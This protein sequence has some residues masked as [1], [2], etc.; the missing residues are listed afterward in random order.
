MSE[1]LR[2]RVSGEQLEQTKTLNQQQPASLDTEL[3]L[4]AIGPEFVLTFPIL[5]GTYRIGRSAD[6]RIQIDTSSISRCHASLTFHHNGV[7]LTDLGSTN[8]TRYGARSIAPDESVA[9]E[10]GVPFHLG[11]VMLILQ[12]RPE[13]QRPRRIWSFGYFEG[14]LEDECVRADQSGG[15]FGLAHIHLTSA[16][17]RVPQCFAAALRSVDVVGAYV[18][19]QYMVLLVNASLSEAQAVADRLLRAVEAVGAGARI[20]LAHFPHDGRNPDALAARARFLALGKDVSPS[21]GAAVVVDPRMR[22][23]HEL[24]ARIASADISVLLMGETG[25]GK[26]IFARRLHELSPR[27]DKP[28]VRIN[29]AALA[30]SLMESE[31]F[32]HERGAFIG[33]V[34]ANPGL[35]LSA[36]G[37]TVFFDEIGEMPAALQTKLLRVLEESTVRPVGGVTPQVIDVRFIAA[38]NRDL[39]RE[40]ARGRFR[41]DLYYRLNAATIVIPPLRERKEEVKPLAEHFI[42]QYCAVTQRLP[43]PRLSEAALAQ[44]VAYPWPGNVRELRNVIERSVVLCTTECIGVEHLPGEKM[45]STFL[46]YPNAATSSVKQLAPS[47]DLPALGAAVDEEVAERERITDALNACAGNQTQAAKM[48]GISRRTLINRMEKYGLPRPRKPTKQ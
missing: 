19:R 38:T 26:E 23:L 2:H 22:E 33:A 41:Q 3:A 45:G 21:D 1:D 30:D 24:T 28:Y 25:V 7:E 42:R 6:C 31:L 14:R 43:E 20:G 39:E 32:G 40:M 13:G 9:I 8:G 10:V 46:S 16:P 35:L 36:N 17:E 44:L 47:V 48:L 12:P 29:C 5:R 37:G 34:H 11:D 15:Q 4:M 18:D 27:A